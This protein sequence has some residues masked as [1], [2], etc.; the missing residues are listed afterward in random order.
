MNATTSTAGAI[1]IAILAL[2]KTAWKLGSALSKLSQEHDLS[3]NNI[4]D[5][6]DGVRSLGN[7]CDNVYAELEELVGSNDSRLPWPDEVDGRIWNC[8]AL[9]IEESNA[10]FRELDKAIMILRGRNPDFVG[11]AHHR[12]L[13]DDTYDPVENFRAC[14]LSITRNLHVTFLVIQTYVHDQPNIV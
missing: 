6:A 7:E 3:G 12:R 2:S 8:L 9:Q 14:V 11:Q 13:F 10:I 4:K 1:S 5:L